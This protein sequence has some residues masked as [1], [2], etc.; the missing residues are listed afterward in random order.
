MLAAMNDWQILTTVLP[1][2][3]SASLYCAAQTTFCWSMRRRAPHVPAVTPWVSILK[4]LAGV[5]DD[6][7]DNL[8]SFARLDYPAFELL[9]GV[10]SPDDPA[11]PI[12]QSFLAAH[13][14]LSARIVWTRPAGGSVY[15]PKVAQLIDLTAAA[16]GSVIVV[17]DANVRVCRTYLRSLIAA[18]LQPGVG[19][20]SSIIRGSGERSLGAA[21]ENAQLGAY[22][23]P[24]VIAAHRFGI[25]PA[26]VGKS[27]AMRVAD[28]A[29]VGGWESVAQVLAE[30]DVMAQ[31]FHAHGYR[32]TVCTEAIDNHVARATIGRTIERHAR[33][34]KMRRA[35]TPGVFY[36]EPLLF[37]LLVATLVALLLPSL[38]AAQVWLA[39]LGLQVIGAML[40]LTVLRARRPVLLALLELLRAAA[41]LAAWLLGCVSRKVVWRGNAFTIGEGSTLTPVRA[42]QGAPAV[43]R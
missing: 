37:P 2:A 43:D 21:L 34:A 15:N 25:R 4:P 13:P 16:R 28:L 9:L 31:R 1:T 33:W 22:V 24:G 30:D 26:T 18:L 39:A 40:S 38:L 7:R 29:R 23:A 8:E 14:E 36:V 32:V 6:L 41:F 11:V 20:V 35:L 19:L 12:V 5:D 10:A 42:E 17:S 3:I 27:M